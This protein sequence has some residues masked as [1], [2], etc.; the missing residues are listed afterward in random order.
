MAAPN[1]LPLPIPVTMPPTMI[2][3]N[4][5]DGIDFLCI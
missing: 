5:R 3:Q 2:N 4:A 1:T